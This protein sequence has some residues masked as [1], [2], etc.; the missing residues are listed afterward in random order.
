MRAV[1]HAVALE[2]ALSAAVKAC[3]SYRMGLTQIGDDAM[4]SAAE[5]ITVAFGAGSP[6][7]DALATVLDVVES[8]GDNA[9]FTAITAGL[10]EGGTP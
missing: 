1:K 9:K 5:M 10:A 4:L 6:G 8:V 7:A 3:A 2:V